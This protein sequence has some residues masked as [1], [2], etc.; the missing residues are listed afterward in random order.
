MVYKQ[1][2]HNRTATERKSDQ[3]HLEVIEHGKKL[4]IP[5]EQL[6]FPIFG[7]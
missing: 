5:P 3:W 2:A 6:D 4:N 7:L 1:I